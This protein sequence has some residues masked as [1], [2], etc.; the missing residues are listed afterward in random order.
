MVFPVRKLDAVVANRSAVAEWSALNR[1][2]A[3]SSS[4]ARISAATASFLAGPG[5]ATN[6]LPE[7][8]VE[9]AST[10]ISARF[11]TQLR[12]WIRRHRTWD[13]A[14]SVLRTQLAG[15]TFAPG[16][17]VAVQLDMM[18]A[19]NEPLTSLWGKTFVFRV[20]ARGQLERRG[21]FDSTS[22]P[23]TLG[24]G[25][26]HYPVTREKGPAYIRSGVYQVSRSLED[27][28]GGTFRFSP[29]RVPT[30]RDTELG[31]VPRDGSIS[32][33]E[34]AHWAAR[35]EHATRILFHSSAYGS[36]GCQVIYS[37]QHP[38]FIRE[39]EA[40]TGST[41]TYVLVRDGEPDTTV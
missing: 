12:D 7:P 31:G 4:D 36:V 11:M 1:S 33:A 21:A 28:L 26:N 18:R 32:A 5:F 15:R 9:R 6:P 30:Y 22:Q 20:D 3:S 2:S 38:D 35:D 14:E 8:R 23:M 40:G 13:R 19:P 41:F 17:I 37:R 34:A 24:I 10:S 29:H 27:Q 39:I 16:N 25:P